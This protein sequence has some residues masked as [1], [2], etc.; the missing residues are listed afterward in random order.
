MKGV[1]FTEL[2]DMIE[3]TFGEDM[4]D[5]IF[6]ECKLASKG[7]YTTVGT[8]D[9]TELLQI[10][11]MLS[12]KSGIAPKNLIQ[13]YAHHLFFRFHDMMPEFFEKSQNAFDFLRSVHDT[14]HVEVKKLY[15]EAALP[16]FE[17]EQKSEKT[18]IMIYNSHCPFA[19]FA[20][21]LIQGCIDFY[22]EDIEIQTNEAEKKDPFSRVFTLNKK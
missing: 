20:H 16:S 21:G 3:T 18:L 1:I 19:D 9:H 2:V 22:K 15:P 8:Y 7:A 5:D 17:T 6:D 13:K 4:M 11:N 12:Q 14:I 10:V